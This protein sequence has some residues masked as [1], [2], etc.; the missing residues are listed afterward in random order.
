MASLA[1]GVQMAESPQIYFDFGNG[2]GRKKFPREIVPRQ[3]FQFAIGLDDRDD[4][5]LRG[6]D[7]L[8]SGDNW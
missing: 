4:A 3:D 5:A 2:R 8:V 7:D 1:Q 6:N